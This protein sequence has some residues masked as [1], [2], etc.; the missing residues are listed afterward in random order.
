M[1]KLT[2]KAILLDTHIAPE[3]SNLETYSVNGKSYHYY[4]LSESGTSAPFA[5]MLDHAKWLQ[6]EAL[7]ALLE[8]S[9]FS[10]IEIIEIRNERNGPRIQLLAKR[11]A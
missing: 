3:S 7:I 9:G 1:S 5:G 10:D 6:Q 11:T 4:R 2:R 8:E